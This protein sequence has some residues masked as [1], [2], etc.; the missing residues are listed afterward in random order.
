MKIVFATLAFALAPSATYAQS[1]NPAVKDPTV[2]TADAA[3]KGHN[4]FTEAQARE[5][6]AKAGF[7]NIGKLVQNENG[8]WQANA[9]KDGKSVTV[10]LDYKGNITVY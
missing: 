1:D 9:V 3:A 4:S 6:I 8:V 7:T 10:A 5:R 2:V